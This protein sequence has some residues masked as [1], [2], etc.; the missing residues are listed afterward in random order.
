MPVILK[1]VHFSCKCLLYL[2]LNQA[3]NC[4]AILNY[5]STPTASK[6]LRT[7]V[8]IRTEPDPFFSQPNHKEKKKGLATWDLPYTQKFSRYVYFTDRKF[9]EIFAIIFSRMPYS[10]EILHFKF[11]AVPISCDFFLLDNMAKSLD[12]YFKRQT[13]GQ[14]SSLPASISQATIDVVKREVGAI[15]VGNGSWQDTRRIY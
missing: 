5:V 4:K 14:S 11:H 9:L 6:V 3:Y 1:R 15:P 2:I 7:S 10:Q 13:E 8:V 12:F